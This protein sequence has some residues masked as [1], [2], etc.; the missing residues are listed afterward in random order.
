MPLSMTATQT[1]NYYIVDLDDNN[2]PIALASGQVQTVISSDPAS[3]VIT[4]DATPQ[5][6]DEDF[7]L[8]DGTLIPKGTVGTGSG[9]VSFGPSA[10][11]GVAVTV[12]EHLANSDGTPVKDSAGNVIADDTDTVTMLPPTASVKKVGMLFAKPV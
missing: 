7:T 1:D 2:K 3:V 9:K 8:A 4:P 10:K 5:P 11:V 12:T 6:T